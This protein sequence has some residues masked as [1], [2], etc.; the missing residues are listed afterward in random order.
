M[1]RMEKIIERIYITGGLV[2]LMVVIM[3]IS[4][5]GVRSCCEKTVNKVYKYEGLYISD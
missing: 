5:C 2:L 4:S 1:N 3:A